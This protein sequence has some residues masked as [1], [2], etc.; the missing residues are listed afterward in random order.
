MKCPHCLVSFHDKFEELNVGED[1]DGKWD[2]L[3]RF[4]PECQ[5]FIYHLQC[6]DFAFDSYSKRNHK[7][8]KSEILVRPKATSRAPIPPEVPKEFS[9][10]YLEA[11]LVL[12]DSLKA[13]AA[14]SRRC[15]QHLLREKAKVTKGDLS[16]EI[17]QVI[18]SGELPGYLKESIDSVRN[19]GNFATHPI[20]SKSSGEILPVEVG[21]AEWN[22]EVIEM[23]FDFYFVQPT[24]LK[25]KKDYLN[26]KL[27]DAGKPEMK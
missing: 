26:T 13:S 1:I 12:S 20:K 5:R 7:I 8:I 18:D 21:E 24:K 15:L 25:Q 3:I 11:C 17:Q 4:C 10:D 2:V 9:M 6:Y 22:L 19:I 27:K 23:L 14:L 16:Y